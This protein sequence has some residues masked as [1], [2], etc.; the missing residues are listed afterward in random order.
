MGHPFFVV[1]AR[2]LARLRRELCF[3][4]YDGAVP[5]VSPWANFFPS[6]REGWCARDPSVWRLWYPTLREKKAKDGATILCGGRKEL[7]AASPR[8]LFFKKCE[9]FY[10][11]GSSHALIQDL[12][13]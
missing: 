3:F 9:G 11:H 1:S 13:R 2:A 5:R 12:F 7:N 4:D 6:L 8:T 10:R